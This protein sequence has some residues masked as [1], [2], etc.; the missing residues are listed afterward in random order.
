M[1]KLD[2][3]VLV[4]WCDTIF[5]MNLNLTIFPRTARTMDVSLAAV[6][7]YFPESGLIITLYLTKMPL[8]Y[9]ARPAIL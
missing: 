5:Q 4:P 6:K 7:L 8:T 1:G 2:L 3:G 9:P